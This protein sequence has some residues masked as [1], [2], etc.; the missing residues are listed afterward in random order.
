[1]ISRDNF[2]QDINGLRALAVLAEK[3]F[4]S[5]DGQPLYTDNN[6]INERGRQKLA[7]M[8]RALLAPRP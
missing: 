7:P 3:C 1:L 6:H 2:R 4:G 5:Q 8:F